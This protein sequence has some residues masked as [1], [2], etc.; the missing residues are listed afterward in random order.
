MKKPCHMQARG[1]IQGL[2]KPLIIAV[3][4]AGNGGQAMAGWL[5]SRGCEVRLTDLFPNYLAPLRRLK[6]IELSGAVQAEGRVTVCR[7]P[8]GCVRGAD[9]IIL[10]TAAPGH[11]R[12]VARM[13]PGLTDG[14]VLLATPGYFSSLTVP[15]YLK[16]LGYKP[17][18]VCAEAESLIYTCRSA[19]PGKVAVYFVKKKM[20]IGVQ[21]QSE[22]RRVLEMI[23]PFYPQMVDEGHSFKVALD[24]VNYAL[25]PAILLFNAGWVEAARGNWIFYKEGVTPSVIRAVEGLDAERLAL[26]SAAGLRLTPVYKLLKKFYRVPGA[27][28][29]LSLLQ[30]NPAYQNIQAPPVL[31]YR[32]FTEDVCYGLVP[33]AALSRKLGLAAPVMDSI[34]RLASL[35]LGR[36]L[37][38]AG[39]RLSDMG[40]ESLGRKEL[41]R[42]LTGQA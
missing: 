35:L 31:D 19:E 11:K 3:L 23:R 27:N 2:R 32:Y 29:L 21:P 4:G 37:G 18:L 36:D 22:A 42:T 5:A 33:M 15:V 20:G 38:R 9:M 39:L 1:R 16:A 41:I 14:Q 17:R 26:G 12:L 24:N 10:A 6:A 30:R 28:H 34:I 8:A 40:L 7:D 25:H 13:A